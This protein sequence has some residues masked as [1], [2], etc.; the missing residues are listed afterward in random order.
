[1]ILT[2][3]DS[4]NRRCIG[5]KLFLPEAADR[6]ISASVGADGRIIERVGMRVAIHEDPAWIMTQLDVGTFFL[7]LLFPSCCWF[8]TVSV[9]LAPVQWP[10]GNRSHL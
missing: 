6:G 5:Y 3:D 9:G 4:T 7:V 1:M 2:I 8:P 10:P